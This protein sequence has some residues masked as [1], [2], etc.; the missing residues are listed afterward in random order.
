M[1]YSGHSPRRKLLLCGPSF[2]T[3][4]PSDTSLPY[5]DF[6]PFTLN[7]LE[8]IKTFMG[9]P[10]TFEVKGIFWQTFAARPK[11]A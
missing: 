6:P 2:N 1:A 5:R 3:A 9:A 4:N 11:A 10:P 8:G 7:L